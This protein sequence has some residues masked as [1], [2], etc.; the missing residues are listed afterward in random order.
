MHVHREDT[1]VVL[2]GKD[3]GKKGRVLKI[4]N[5]TEKVLVEKINMVKRHTRPSQELPQ[6][7]IVEKEAAIHVSNLQVVCLKCGKP[8][9]ISHKILSSG[10][11]TRACKKCGEILDKEK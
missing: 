3:R 11:K 1:V 8:T 9:R 4:I 10:K 5:K 6:G 7:G 2:V